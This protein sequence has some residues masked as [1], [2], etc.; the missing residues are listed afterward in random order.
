MDEETV[1]QS[2]IEC[3]HI[4]FKGIPHEFMQKHLLI[5]RC[6]KIDIVE[7]KKNNKAVLDL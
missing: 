5:K 2:E 4:A 1:I 6:T 7:G 3:R